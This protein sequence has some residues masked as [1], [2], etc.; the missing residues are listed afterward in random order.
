MDTALDLIYLN[1]HEDR[2]E[3]LETMEIDGKPMS[4]VIDEWTYYRV[5]GGHWIGESS[6]QVCRVKFPKFEDTG[7]V[8]EL[9]FRVGFNG[10][11]EELETV[12]Q[13]QWGLS[14]AKC[15]RIGLIV[16]G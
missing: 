15:I 13:E 10:V 3:R 1:K 14:H 9:P 4:V 8:I 16:T 2:P 5:R 11:P 7:I 12:M 6:V